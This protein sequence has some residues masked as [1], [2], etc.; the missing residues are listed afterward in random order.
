MYGNSVSIEILHVMEKES[1][2]IQSILMFVLTL[3]VSMLVLH[4][5]HLCISLK[6]RKPLYNWNTWSA[7][8]EN[9]KLKVFPKILFWGAINSLG[10]KKKK[11]PLKTKFLTWVFSTLFLLLLLLLLLFSWDYS[12]PV[13]TWSTAV[14][15]VSITTKN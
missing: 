14:V 15:T 4:P 1:L 12:S 9:P 7:H 6:L 2:P 10:E 11:Q 8:A 3:A 5:T 13:K